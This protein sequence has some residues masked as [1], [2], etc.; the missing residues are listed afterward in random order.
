[1]DLSIVPEPAQIEFEDKWLRFDGFRNAPDFLTSEFGIP[2]GSWEVVEK[3][4]D[5]QAISI[6]DGKVTIT[7]NRYA[8]YATLLQLLRQ[9]QGM[10]PVTRVREVFRFDFRCYHLDIARG[11]VPRVN[12]FKELLHWLFLL[13]YNFL[14]IYYEDLYPWN[15]HPDIGRKRG[16]LRKEELAQ[17]ES[18]A[19]SL[20]IGVIPSLEL[21]G[22]MEHTLAL[23]QYRKYAELWWLSHRAADGCI[24]PGNAD[25]SELTLSLLRDVLETSGSEF[26]H[27]GGDETWS[28]GRGRSLDRTVSYKGPELFLSHYEKLLEEVKKH[29]K[30]PILWGDMLTGMY[31]TEEEKEKWAGVIKSKIWNDALIAN[32]DYEPENVEHFRE[33]IDSIGRLD[34]Q[35]ACPSVHNHRRFYPEFEVALANIKNFLSAAREKRLKGFMVTAWGDDGSECLYSFL[36]PLLLAC[37]EYAEGNGNWEEKWLRLSGESQ[38][39]LKARKLFGGRLV[40]P[41]LKSVLYLASP[42]YHIELDPEEVRKEWMEVLDETKGLALPNDLAFIRNSLEAGLKI[43]EHAAKA[44]DLTELARKYAELWLKERK[45][46]GLEAILCRLWGSAGVLEAGISPP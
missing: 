12:A 32:W 30:Q 16:G 39:L 44:S 11:G 8:G 38:E 18:Y 10:L 2:P 33:K 43:I 20:G 45:P 1:M 35:L 7:G 5:T 31:L 23:P 28:L 13:K 41:V 4:S 24:D 19:K 27:I 22:H 14:A 15:S 37:M 26:V 3:T 42:Q 9:R 34:K 40:S 21:L 46:N 36:N 17:I 6:E 25:A 29:R